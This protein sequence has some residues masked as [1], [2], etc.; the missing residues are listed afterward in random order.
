MRTEWDVLPPAHDGLDE[1]PWSP[2][3][4][5]AGMCAIGDDC[6]VRSHLASIR[7]AETYDTVAPLQQETDLEIA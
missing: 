2:L 5:K 6:V 1:A 4:R 3:A 7:A